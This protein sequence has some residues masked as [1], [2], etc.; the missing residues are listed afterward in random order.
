MVDKGLGIF[1]L[2][3]RV[4]TL[5][6]KMWGSNTQ[7]RI[8]ERGNCSSTSK[9]TLVERQQTSKS[10]LVH[11]NNLYSVSICISKCT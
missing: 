1:A 10:T 9:I 2:R 5:L 7:L 4:S 8:R 11:G 6:G 3:G